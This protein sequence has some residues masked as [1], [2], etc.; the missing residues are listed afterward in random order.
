MLP[1]EH[2]LVQNIEKVRQGST[3]NMPE[4]LMWKISL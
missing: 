3:L 4:I 1:F 2:D